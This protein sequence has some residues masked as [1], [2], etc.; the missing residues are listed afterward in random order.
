MKDLDKKESED[1]KGL[2]LQGQSERVK[3]VALPNIPT[4]LCLI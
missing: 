4:I 3:E 1:R 2:I